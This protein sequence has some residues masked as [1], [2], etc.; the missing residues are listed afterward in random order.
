MNT[1]DL[2]KLITEYGRDIYNFCL[3]LTMN[4]NEAE[5]LYQDT[6]LTA[7]DKVN[8]EGNPKSYLL[9]TALRLWQ[10]K[11]R[12]TAWR[13]R[14][15]PEDNMPE[16]ID[17]SSHVTPESEYIK[18]EERQLVLKTVNSLKEPLRKTVILYYSSGLT[19]DETAE[20]LGVPSG[21]VKSRLHK[22]RE[23]LKH[24]LEADING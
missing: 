24:E 10:N 21:T 12:K 20:I 6:F 13:H 3:R 17:I 11:R 14:I 18:K 16:G 8:N 9:G 15:A 23:I 22:A 1:E 19:I 2:T 4:K 7:M 5:K